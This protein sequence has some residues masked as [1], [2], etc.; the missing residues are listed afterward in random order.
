MSRYTPKSIKAI[1][2]IDPKHYPAIHNTGSN[3]YNSSELCLLSWLSYHYTKVNPG[4]KAPITNF[5]S[6]LHDCRVF[7]AAVISHVPSVQLS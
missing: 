3:V 5:D 2:G 1:P 4:D 6:D 7:A